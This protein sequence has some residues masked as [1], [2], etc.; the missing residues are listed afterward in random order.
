MIIDIKDTPQFI[1]RGLLLFHEEA[2][3]ADDDRGK[4]VVNMIIKSGA[5]GEQHHHYYL[6]Q[7][8]SSICSTRLKAQ[9]SRNP[10]DEKPKKESNNRNVE[11]L[12]YSRNLSSFLFM[13]VDKC[14]H[15]CVNHLITS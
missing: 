15:C 11:S 1:R 2:A 4:K 12:K 8:Y 7:S 9:S 3:A 14:S 5:N 6:P 13:L 10:T